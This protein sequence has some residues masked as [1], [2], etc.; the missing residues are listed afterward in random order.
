[1]IVDHALAG[2]GPLGDLVDPRAAEA[3]VGEFLGR[4]GKDVRAGTIR[5][6][7]VGGVDLFGFHADFIAAGGA[8]R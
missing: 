8:R 4:D 2:V 6:A 1:M 3:L 5:P 7:Y